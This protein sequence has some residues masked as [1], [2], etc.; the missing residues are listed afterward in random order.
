[1]AASVQE[2]I[3]KIDI[4]RRRVHNARTRDFDRIHINNRFEFDILQ[5]ALELLR[6][7]INV[8]SRTE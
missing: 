7:T 1:M 8:G 3:N 6:Q 5:K 4:L 2:T